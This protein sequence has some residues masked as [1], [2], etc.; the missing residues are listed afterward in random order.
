MA[1]SIKDAWEEDG[2]L[3]MLEYHSNMYLSDVVDDKFMNDDFPLYFISI[4]GMVKFRMID[5]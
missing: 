4:Y 2:L 3:G 1:Y 5:S